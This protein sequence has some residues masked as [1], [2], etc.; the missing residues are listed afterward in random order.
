MKRFLLEEGYKGTRAEGNTGS[1]EKGRREGTK[2]A[3]KRS[4]AGDEGD[5]R[6][7]RVSGGKDN[8]SR[9]KRRRRRR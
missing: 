4:E 6:K 3:I 8:S 5:E 9:M 1:K 2:E 7:E